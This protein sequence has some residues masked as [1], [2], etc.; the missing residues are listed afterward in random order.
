MR[1]T[2][3]LQYRPLGL[4]CEPSQAQLEAAGVRKLDAGDFPQRQP[5]ALPDGRTIMAYSWIVYD[6]V[7]PDHLVVMCELAFGGTE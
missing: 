3:Y 2:Y 5:V 1:T 7:L 6:G 4:G